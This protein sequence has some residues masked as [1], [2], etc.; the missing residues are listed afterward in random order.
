MNKAQLT[1]LESFLSRVP[2]VSALGFR[3]ALAHIV[4]DVD[5]ISLDKIECLYGNAS[6]LKKKLSLAKRCVK[7]VVIEN[8]P[9]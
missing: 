6:T 2:N 7:T 1:Q 8:E 3:A 5:P 4:A 9:A